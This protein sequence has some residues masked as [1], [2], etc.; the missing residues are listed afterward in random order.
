[1]RGVAADAPDVEVARGKTFLDLKLADIRASAAR[2]HGR[3]PTHLMTSFATDADV[4]RMARAA[5]CKTLFY[6]AQ[7]PSSWSR[8]RVAL[9][10]RAGVKAWQ[11]PSP[12]AR[13][14][15]TGR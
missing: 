14:V 12:L 13:P 7:P 5:C 2:A 6:C 11:S 15:F 9:L 4:S 8:L 10:R 1:V 3:V